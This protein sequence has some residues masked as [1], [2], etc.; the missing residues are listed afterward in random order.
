MFLNDAKDVYALRSEVESE[1]I[2]TNTLLLGDSVCRL[3]FGQKKDSST[4]SLCENQSYELPGNYLLLRSLLENGSRFDTLILVMNP[5]TMVSSLNQPYTYNYFIKP[6]RNRLHQL[7]SRELRYINETFPEW[8]ALKYRFSTFSFPDPFDI[9]K[10]F[11]TDSLEISSINR[12]Y[13]AKMDSICQAENIVFK[14]ISPPLP[15]NNRDYVQRFTKETKAR[16][17]AYFNSII[18][19]DSIH[20][21]DRLHPVDSKIFYQE[22]KK[23]LDSLLAN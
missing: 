6:F 21:K 19:Y 16:N 22:N 13:L 15:S 23:Q 10:D 20:S 18:Y 2:D 5:R 8:D 1:P 3:L 14:I 12:K 17:P 4:Y 7:E 11:P 9:S